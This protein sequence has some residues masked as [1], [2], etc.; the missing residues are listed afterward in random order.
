MGMTSAQQG[1]LRAQLRHNRDTIR[2]L[3]QARLDLA[4]KPYVNVS[5][6]TGTGSRT[7]TLRST[8]AAT[9]L[10]DEYEA[11]CAAIDRMLKS[12]SPGGIRHIEIV[13]C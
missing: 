10:I 8:D 13:R 12:A 5:I 11:K 4:L 2:R 3:E 7:V 9:S 1:N 6:S